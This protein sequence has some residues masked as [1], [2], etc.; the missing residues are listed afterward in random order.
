MDLEAQL[1][2][3]LSSRAA[4]IDTAPAGL[5]DDVLAGHRRSVHHRRA[6]VIAVA[7]AAVA[8]VAIPLTTSGGPASPVADGTGASTAGAV[9][10]DFRPF[11]VSPRGSLAGDPAYLEALVELPWSTVPEFAGPPVSTRAVV[12]ADDGVDG[13]VALVIGWQDGGWQ[14]LWLEGAPGAAVADLAPSGDATPVDPGW[15]SEYTGSQLLLLGRPGDVIE[16]SPRQDISADGSIVPAPFAVVST[17]DGTAVLDGSGL[18]TATIR[19]TRDGTVVADA[20][21]VGGQDVQEGSAQ[22][23]DLSAALG[24]AAGEPEEPMVRLM[25]QAVLNRLGLAPSEVTVGVRWG[26]AIGNTALDA[27]SA[28]VTVGLP[29]GATVLVGA[30]GSEQEVGDTFVSI[31]PCAQTILPAG[32]DVDGLLVAMRC[33]LTALA[34]GRSLGNQVVVVPPAGTATV[35]LTGADGVVIDARDLDGPAFVGPAP[36]GL[37]GVV[38]LDGDGAV[39]AQAPLL[40]ITPLQLD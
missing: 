27:T 4:D 11:D 28:V 8:A 35:Q 25:V 12:W 32:T 30:V 37:Q 19:V 5:V 17:A 1:R 13:V 7:V 22:Q 20:T 24:T 33:D 29:S 23:L 38:A 39:L 31:T 16:V 15:T 21:R 18:G 6:A 36:D 14:G 2:A 40:G 10:A 3:G 34:D 26:G 9:E